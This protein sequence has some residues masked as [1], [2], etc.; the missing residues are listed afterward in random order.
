M[1]FSGWKEFL[2]KVSS[3]QDETEFNAEF[4][5]MVSLF[6]KESSKTP[7]SK[8]IH[9]DFLLRRYTKLLSLDLYFSNFMKKKDKFFPL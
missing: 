4:Q 1:L 6:E 7:F 2:L 8:S 9:Y 3:P 5:S